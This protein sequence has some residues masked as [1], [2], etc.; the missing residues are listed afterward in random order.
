MEAEKKI[1]GV[2]EA[3]QKAEALNQKMLEEKREMEELL[4]K[5]DTAVRDMENKA[6]KI[7][8]ERKQLDKEVRRRRKQTK[9]V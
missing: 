4:A 8:N 5:G 1:D 3:R 9:P 7:E 2:K 6:K